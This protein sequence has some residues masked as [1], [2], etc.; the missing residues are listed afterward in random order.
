MTTQHRIEER[1]EVLFA[2]HRA[3]NDPT[4]EQI[5]EWVQRFPQFADD[6]LAHAVILKDWADGESLPME[7]AEEAM[8]THSRSRALDALSCALLSL[9]SEQSSASS[10]SYGDLPMVEPSS[11]TPNA[12]LTNVNQSI[13]T[14][15]ASGLFTIWNRRQFQSAC[16]VAVATLAL[17]L[18]YAHN[19]RELHRVWN[20]DPNYSHGYL[21]IPIAL[22]VLWRRLSDMPAKS[23]LATAPAYWWGWVALCAVL[24][25]R[26]IAYERN[27]QWLEAATLVPAAACLA[28]SFGSWP[29]LRRAWPAIGFLVFMLPL[30]SVVNSSISLPLQ[31]IAATGSCFLLQL[32]GLWAI[33]EGNVIHIATDHGMVPLDVAVACNGLRMLTTMAATITAVIILMPLPVWKRIT[34]LASAVPIAMFS[35]IVRITATGWCYRLVTGP[36]A[37]DWAHDVS[38]WLMMPLALILVGLELLLLTW[39]VPAVSEAEKEDQKLILPVFYQMESRKSTKKNGARDELA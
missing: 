2:L 11:F 17:G 36:A 35:N 26:A 30:P 23:P 33:Q 6:I 39:L 3:V 24:A 10:Q 15:G 12:A 8:L 22:V 9:G 18:A 13:S 32:S 29:L 1:D 28:W 7:E 21:V 31:R 16:A 38:G 4:A 25:L 27:A 37:K 20:N 34:L 14:L 19:L 5:I